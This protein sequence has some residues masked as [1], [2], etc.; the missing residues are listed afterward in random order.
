MPTKRKSILPFL[1]KS[2]LKKWIWKSPESKTKVEIDFVLSYSRQI[3]QDPS[4][5]NNGSEHRVNRAATVINTRVKWDKIL[6]HHN[7]PINEELSQNRGQFQN[8]LHT[9]LSLIT[10]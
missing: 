10:T 5:L 7:Y 6:N 4:V 3:Y 1:K 9:K 8:I 2:L